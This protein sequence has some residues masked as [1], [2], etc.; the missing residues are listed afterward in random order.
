MTTTEAFNTLLAA[1]KA[2]NAEADAAETAGRDLECG[3]A[4]AKL[5]KL[6]EAII[7]AR[8]TELAP[9]AAQL[10]WLARRG[11][12]LR[13]DELVLQHIVEQLERLAGPGAVLLS[14]DAA[15]RIRCALVT[16]L[17][18]S[19]GGIA[20]EDDPDLSPGIGAAAQELERQLRTAYQ[21]LEQTG[22]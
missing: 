11:S 3:R 7:A 12:L 13:E 4:R 19:G 21:L 15:A 16:V 2:A 10:R 9:M 22:G 8:P 6:A 20:P 1:C 18:N 5:R 17:E 14:A